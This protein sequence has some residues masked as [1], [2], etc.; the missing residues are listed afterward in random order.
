MRHV[1]AFGLVLAILLLAAA[2]P[3]VL[4]SGAAG[5]SG[6]GFSSF[7]KRTL[8]GGT[9][10]VAVSVPRA[11]D[12]CT[13]G[14]AYANGAIQRGLRTLVSRTA[15][16][17]WTWTVPPA[18]KSGTAQVS[19]ACRDS[20]RISRRLAVVGK[21]L[22]PKIDVVKQGFSVRAQFG[23]ASVSYGVVLANRSK[24]DDAL[25]VQVLVN[26]VNPSNALVGTSTTTLT[27]I[28]AGGEYA[29]GKS[30]T[31]DG[32]V[33]RLEIVVE[34]GN[35]Q[36]AIRAPVPAVLNGAIMPGTFDAKWVGAVN[37]ELTNVSKS[38]VLRSAGLS[39]VV[40]NAAGEVVG[41]GSGAVYGTLPPGARE[42]VQLTFGFDS[43]LVSDAATVQF[44]VDPSYVSNDS[45]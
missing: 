35:K 42:F 32:T 13:L 31:V 5:S 26:F 45:G 27:S 44:S 25:D 15:G 30:A 14:V 4:A 9:A 3:A 7:P 10:T 12:R 40:L 38:L 11:N 2:A 39:A 8:A 43:V 37:G 29:L 28:P 1:R 17:T 21:V 34:V 6:L 20:G 16:L 24:T 19:V 22:P 23:R 36:P 18:T 33:S 41:G